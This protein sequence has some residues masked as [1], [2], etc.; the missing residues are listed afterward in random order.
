[1]AAVP[2]C[3]SCWVCLSRSECV[4]RNVCTLVH[5]VMGW[6]EIHW[7]APLNPNGLGF[8]QTLLHFRLRQALGGG[9]WQVVSRGNS[10]SVAG[11]VQAV[12]SLSDI[13]H[14]TLPERTV[15]LV[16]GTV[17]GMQ[18]IPDGHRQM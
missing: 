12:R 10:P 5:G 1:M 9:S 18:A 13:Q 3:R 6:W 7:A 4:R 14:E 16:E 17:T 11:R 15:L 8:T 2:P